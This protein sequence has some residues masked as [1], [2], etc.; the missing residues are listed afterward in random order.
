LS[1]TGICQLEV[2]HERAPIDIPKFGT[3]DNEAGAGAKS[4]RPKLTTTRGE[5]SVTQA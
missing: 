2:P 5:S 3:I 4:E 1:E